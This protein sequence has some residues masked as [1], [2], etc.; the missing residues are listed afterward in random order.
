[1]PNDVLAVDAGVAAFITLV[2]LAAH[3]VKH[4]L[5]GETDSTGGSVSPPPSVPCRC[6]QPWGEYGQ[7]SLLPGWEFSPERAHAVSILLLAYHLT[8]V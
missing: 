3:M 8:R 1:M 6:S 4:V 7:Q 2:G 5:L